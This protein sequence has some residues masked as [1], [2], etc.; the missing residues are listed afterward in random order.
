M[1]PFTAH[2]GRVVAL[3]RANVDTD[4]IIPKQFLKRIE[5]TGFGPS[6]F[7][8]W[9][10]L[11]DGSPNPDFELNRPEAAG[12][13]HSARRR[14]I[15]AAARSREHAPWA[16]ADYGFRA[17]IAPVVRRHLLRQLL[18]ERAAAGGAARGRGPSCFAGRRGRR[19]ATSVTVD[20]RNRR[21]RDGA[22]LRGRRSRS[23]TIGAR[24]CSRG[25]TR[26]GRTLLEEPRIAAFERR[27]AALAARESGMTRYTVAVLP[28]DGIGPEVTAEAVRVLRA[29]ADLYGFGLETTE[30]RR[31]RGGGRG[32]G[33][34]AA[35][36]PPR[37][38]VTQADA[39]LLGAVGQPALAAAEGGAGRRPVCWRSGSCSA[40]TPTCG[41]SRCIRRCA[42]P[43]R[44]GP[45][46]WTA[47]IC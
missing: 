26:S 8:D 6:L 7:Y 20:L 4:Q 34:R 39:V 32:G 27:R 25:W 23:M 3:P 43:R 30:Y 47:W 2:T 44:S 5:R 38:R 15:S 42:T 28:G 33:R 45:S 31:R 22:G 36:A 1:Q 9:R 13:T 41:R 29:V 37:R 46:G 14:R 10:Y 12:A 35:A 19:T 18:P 16:L 21:V 40:P 17:I 24:C 11:A